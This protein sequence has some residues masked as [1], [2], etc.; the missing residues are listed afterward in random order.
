MSQH[1]SH[2]PIVKTKKSYLKIWAD[3]PPDFNN[4]SLLWGL[5]TRQRVKREYFP[6]SFHATRKRE[7]QNQK[8]LTQLRF[9]KNLGEA[10]T[11]AY[12]LMLMTETTVILFCLD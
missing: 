4:T 7:G 11:S 2:L 8:E 9:H 12:T 3:I 10:V 5:V 6:L 1:P